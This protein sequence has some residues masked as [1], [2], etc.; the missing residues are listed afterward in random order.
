MMVPLDDNFQDLKFVLDQ[1]NPSTSNCQHQLYLHFIQV[2]CQF[3]LKIFD[4]GL[5]IFR[6]VVVVFMAFKLIFLVENNLSS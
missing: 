4:I 1:S 5:Q 6:V 2:M 3:E